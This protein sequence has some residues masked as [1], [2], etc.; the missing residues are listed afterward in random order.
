M[1]ARRGNQLLKAVGS[2]RGCPDEHQGLIDSAE[3]VDFVISTLE[4]GSN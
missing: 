4:A 3:S 2:A 1:I